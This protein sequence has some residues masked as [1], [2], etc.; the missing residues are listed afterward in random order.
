[1]LYH[2]K[3]AETYSFG[4]ISWLLIRRL[5][6]LHKG[7]ILF[8]SNKNKK[9]SVMLTF[10][11]VFRKF[12]SVQHSLSVTSLFRT[13]FSTYKKHPDEEAF[14]LRDTVRGKFSERENREKHS[15]LLV[16]EN[17]EFSSFLIQVLSEEYNVHMISGEKLCLQIKSDVKTAHIPVILFKDPVNVEDDSQRVADCCLALPLDISRLRVEINNLIFNRRIIRKRYIT[18]V[19]GGKDEAKSDLEDAFSGDEQNFLDKVRRLVEENLSNPDFN[20]DVLSAEMNMSRSG[21]YTRIKSITHQAPADYIRT[22]KL[23]KALILLMSKKYTVAEVADLTGFSDPKYFRE[24][25]KKYYGES[26]KKFVNSL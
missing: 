21:F 14:L 20:V 9:A 4:V 5:I 17:R 13:S 22:V 2:K 18:L 7:K 16:E 23:N 1:M 8:C 11:I 6:Q 3:G 15:I 10:P 25:F 19:L 24:V 26:P 12:S